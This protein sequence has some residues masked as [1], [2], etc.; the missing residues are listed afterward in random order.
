MI[1]HAHIEGQGGFIVERLIS[2]LVEEIMSDWLEC[3]DSLKEF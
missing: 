2:L 3:K 1:T